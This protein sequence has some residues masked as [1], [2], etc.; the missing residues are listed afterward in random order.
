MQ[1]IP[2]ILCGGSGTR[3]WPKSQDQQP[4][5]FM[6]LFS[7]NT[8][9][10]DTIKRAIDVTGTSPDACVTVTYAPLADIVKK[11]VNA[12][13]PALSQH[14]LSEPYRRNTGAAIAF[15][16][17]YVMDRFG[18]DAY[19]VSFPSDHYI[20]DHDK[21]KSA[22][23][24]AVKTAENGYLVSIGIV[25]SR[26]EPGYGYIRM[27]KAEELNGCYGVDQFIE[28]PPMKQAF[29]M[30]EDGH[31][32]WSTAIHIFKASTV[33]ERYKEHAPE[34]IEKLAQGKIDGD[35]QN[36][37]KNMPNVSF[38]DSVLKKTTQIATI[39]GAFNWSDIGTWNS[40]WELENK[41][42]S[43]NVLQG[44]VHTHNTANCLIQSS[45]KKIATVSVQDL[46]IIDS[47]DALLIAHKD[48]N[49]G[50]RQVV[51]KIQAQQA[52]TAN[53]AKLGK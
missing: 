51:G 33:L 36:A 17:Q 18:E 22:I 16:A 8:L 15:A 45:H 31:Y 27:N 4:K 34:I 40:I 30:V 13:H 28:K 49:D 10:Q 2:I 39:P 19:I 26:P 7:D 35:Y 11:Q 12:I 23:Q 52:Q 38:E 6:K 3:L 32:L 43:G 25:P 29:Q 5:Q 41:D 1:I 42:T 44:D 24:T 9:L 53:L 14:I 21:L 20:Q 37:F 50:L 47:P 48:D 46:I